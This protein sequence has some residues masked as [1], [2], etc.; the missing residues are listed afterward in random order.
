M[1]Q[2]LSKTHKYTT[3]SI[4]ITI[5]QRLMPYTSNYDY[6]ISAEYMHSTTPILS[7]HPMY[8][9]MTKK[10]KG[11]TS[12]SY[13]RYLIY[14]LIYC[15]NDRKVSILQILYTLERYYFYVNIKDIR[16]YL[17]LFFPLLRMVM[18]NRYP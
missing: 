10:T 18:Y 17:I 6:Y 7:I 1:L 12:C 8:A 3:F 14:F 15:N 4:V 9:Y 13:K 16:T 2:L 5:Q 11:Q